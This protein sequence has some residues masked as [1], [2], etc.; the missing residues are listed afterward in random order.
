MVFVLFATLHGK[1]HRFLQ[2][3]SNLEQMIITYSAITLLVVMQ[4]IVII[5]SLAQGIYIVL[6]I[7][8]LNIDCKLRI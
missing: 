8:L 5:S 2:K 1:V 3:L 6:L 7:R 4:K